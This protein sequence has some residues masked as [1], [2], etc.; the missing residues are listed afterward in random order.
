M[1]WKQ[2]REMVDGHDL[3]YAYSDDG[4]VWRRG[5]RQFKDIQEAALLFPRAEVEKYWNAMVD[6]CLSEN[7]RKDFYWHSSWK[8]KDD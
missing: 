2:F 5:D 6:K 4:S 3:T 1:R 8:C 7:A